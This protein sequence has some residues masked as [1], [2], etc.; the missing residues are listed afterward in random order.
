MCTRC[1]PRI[2]ADHFNAGLKKR[3]QER[4]FFGLAL[5]SWNLPLLRLYPTSHLLDISNKMSTWYVERASKLNGEWWCPLVR[6]FL[7]SIDH[8]NLDFTNIS[9]GFTP[10]IKTNLARIKSDKPC[11]PISVNGHN[12][13][14]SSITLQLGVKQ[15]LGSN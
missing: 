14:R 8:N 13:S 11:Y 7:I 1:W 3:L 6:F 4:S 15:G 9:K 10:T 2:F 5:I 12:F